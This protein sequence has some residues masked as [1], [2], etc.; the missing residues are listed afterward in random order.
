MLTKVCAVLPD[1]L[2][3]PP[4]CPMQQH[5]QL[6]S[7]ILL[8]DD[9]LNRS[10]RL[11]SKCGHFVNVSDAAAL[12]LAALLFPNV[13]NERIFAV[14]I[15]WTRASINQILS[16]L[17]PERMKA[18]KKEGEAVQR[19]SEESMDLTVFKDVERAEELLK[20]MGRQGWR[21]LE[22]SVRGAVEGFL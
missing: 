22:G 10:P 11:G 1:T 21:D 19:E 4:V 2:W 12:H 9:I 13:R 6:P 20:R 17:F 8:L 15:P 16:R 14:S 3:G 5:E 18:L 7:S